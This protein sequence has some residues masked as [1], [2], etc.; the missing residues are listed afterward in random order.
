LCAGHL[1]V[2]DVDGLTEV[3]H[4]LH[5]GIR[6]HENRKAD[7]HAVGRVTDELEAPE[8]GGEL[9]RH[10][11]RISIHT[12]GTQQGLQLVEGELEVSAVLLVPLVG[13]GMPNGWQGVSG[14]NVDGCPCDG[15]EDSCGFEVVTAVFVSMVASGDGIP[16]NA[17]TLV[18]L[19][20]CKSTEI[21]G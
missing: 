19:I 14:S 17:V 7:A 8:I 5:G 15:A 2:V 9:R 11:D 1:L 12:T 4:R 6:D 18:Q 13:H 20:T 21:L 3:G 16:F 10:M